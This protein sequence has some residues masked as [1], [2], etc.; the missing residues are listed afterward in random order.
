[1][2]WR[3]Q[4]RAGRA[5]RAAFVERSSRSGPGHSM[6]GPDQAGA[7]R[8]PPSYQGVEPPLSL[9]WSGWS[10]DV[11]PC[12][13][14]GAGRCRPAPSLRLEEESVRKA[15]AGA[16]R[17]RVPDRSDHQRT[18]P[19][20]RKDLRPVS[21]A[22]PDDPTCPRTRGER[23]QNVSIWDDIAEATA[24]MSRPARL[25]PGRHIVRV[26]NLRTQAQ[27]GRSQSVLL[28]ATVVSSWGH[29]AHL[30]GSSASWT[31]DFGT[32]WGACSLRRTLVALTGRAAADIA[33]AMGPGSPVCVWEAP[34]P[35]GERL[36]EAVV[37]RRRSKGSGTTYWVASFR[38]MPSSYEPPAAQPRREPG[39]G[40]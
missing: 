37:R 2:R 21:P 36:M 24:R 26:R 27:G 39:R 5:A 22:S 33:P 14:R 11:P 35:P 12:P 4:E 8:Q 6:A 10:Q 16:S 13:S 25:R 19:A 32:S 31:F 29:D 17:P 7:A 18:K 34:G 1:M 20:L 15:P 28:T 38:A 23:D 40:A 30:P 9:S 3:L